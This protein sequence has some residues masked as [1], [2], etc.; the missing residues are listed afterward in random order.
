MSDFAQRSPEWYAERLGKVTASRVAD[1]MSVTKSGPSASRHTYMLDLLCQ[2]L[3]GAAEPVYT[4]AAM[5]RGVDLEPIARSAYESETGEMVTECGLVMHQDIKDF[6][7]SPDGLVC[8]DGLLEIKCPGSR[9]HLD[10][11]LI[12]KPKTEY[13]WQMHAQMECTG[14]EWCD[15][16]SFDDR[17]PSNIQYKRVRVMRDDD[18]CE[19][20]LEGISLFLNELCDLENNLIGF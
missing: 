13:I 19:K 7:A 6:G 3:T 20:M 12:G 1:V 18:R 15:F 14:R 11:L 2:R 9:A 5:Q 16:V 17:F 10:F 8:D 4:T